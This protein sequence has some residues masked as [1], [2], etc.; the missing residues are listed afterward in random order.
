MM[1]QIKNSSKSKLRGVK[2][3]EVGGAGVHRAEHIK[4]GVDCKVVYHT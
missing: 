3:G 2:A 4:G 1:A